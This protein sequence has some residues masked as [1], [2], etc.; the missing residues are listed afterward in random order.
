MTRYLTAFN[1]WT[2]DT[3]SIRSGVGIMA[4]RS[5]LVQHCL[6]HRQTKFYQAVEAFV[7]LHFAKR[8]S[9]D[10]DGPRQ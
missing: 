6:S 7:D 1:K 2:S 8:T 5:W 3:Y 4:L 9:S 10:P